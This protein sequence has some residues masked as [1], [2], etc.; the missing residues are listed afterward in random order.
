MRDIFEMWLDGFAFFFLLMYAG[1]SIAILGLLTNEPALIIFGIIWEIVTIFC[2][3]DLLPFKIL[4]GAVGGALF[5]MFGGALFGILI[6]DAG[7]VIVGLVGG[8]LFGSLIGLVI[9][10]PILHPIHFLFGQ[11]R[12]V[13]LFIKLPSF[14]KDLLIIIETI[15][16]VGIMTFSAGLGINLASDIYPAVFGPVGGMAIVGWVLGMIIGALV[17]HKTASHYRPS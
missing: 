2:F 5:G 12:I 7:D 1:I 14:F 9:L 8:A 16:F 3:R 6:G 4:V 17:M 11:E 13:R 10:G 15:L